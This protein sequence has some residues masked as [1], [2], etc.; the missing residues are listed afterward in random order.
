MNVFMSDVFPTG[1]LQPALGQ[2]YQG[3]HNALTLLLFQGEMTKHT[4]GAKP[5]SYATALEYFS[6]QCYD[7]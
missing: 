2:H 3:I 6:Q 5:L 4:K 1:T 7:K